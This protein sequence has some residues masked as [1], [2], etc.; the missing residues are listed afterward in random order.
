MKKQILCAALSVAM[1]ATSV[2]VPLSA[3]AA[4]KT[5]QYQ[6][7][8]RQMEDLDRGLIAVYRTADG[9]N[10]MGNEA[11][12]YLSWRLLGTESLENQAF[13]IYRG[14]EL[15]ATTGVHDATN[16]IDKAGRA[17]DEYRVLPAGTPAKQV[18]KEPAVKPVTNHV[19]NGGSNL[20][21]SFTYEDIRIERPADSNGGH[22]YT[23]GSQEGGANDASV[24]D[25]DGDGQYEIV[26]KWDPTN[27]KDAS[28]GGT[29]GHTI[30][31]AYEID[32]TN[33]DPTKNSNGHLYKWRID[34]GS[35]VRA[36]AHENPF[37]VYD[38]DGDG[39]AEMVSITGKDSVDGTGQYVT[40]VGDTEEI[41]N[42]SN[43]YDASLLRKG[44]NIGP[45]YYTVFDGETGAALITTDAIPIGREDGG[46]WGDSKMQRSSRYLAGVAYIDGVHP[47]FVMGRG[48]YNRS[49]IRAYTWDGN[50]ATMLWEHDGNVDNATTM[51]GQGA[52]SLSIGDIDNDGKDEVVYISASLDDDGRTVLG[53]TRLGHGDA[54]HLSD[55]NND[56]MQEIFSV[57]EKEWGYKYYGYDFVVAATGQHFWESGK[58]KTSG[59]NGRGVMAN[60]DDEYAKTHPNALAIGWDSGHTMSHD[61]NGDDIAAKPAAAGKG[62]FDNFLVYWDGDLSRELLDANI[63]QKYDAAT[64]ISTRFYGENDGYTLTG[65]VTNNYTKRNPCLVADLWGDWREEII[66]ATGK[67]QNETPALRIFTSTIPT[68]YRLTTLMHDSQYRLAIAWQNVGYNQPPHQ[69]YYIGSVALATDEDGNTLNYLAPAVP[70]TNVTTEAPQAVAATGITLD[71]SSAKVEK[72]K[73]ITIGGKVLPENAS[74]KAITWVSSNTSVATVSNGIVKGV[75]AGT[76]TITATTKDG[77]FSATC[78]VEVYSKPVTGV[79]LSERYIEIG[80]DGTKQLTATVY[81]SDATDKSVTW[82]S[83][84]SGIATVASDGTVTGKS[85][86]KT[87]V[88]ATTNDGKKVASCIVKV[89]NM[90]LTDATGTGAFAFVGTPGTNTT[91][92][93]NTATGVKLNMADA[94]TGAVAQKSFTQTSGNKATLKFNFVTG[95]TK[96]DGSNWN[97]S[98]HEYSMGLKF[99]DENGNNIMNIVQPYADKAGTLTCVTGEDEK[100]NVENWTK[101][102]DGIGNIQG[103]AK[104]WVF[105]AEFDYDKDTCTVDIMGTDDNYTA[106]N[107]EYTHTFDLNGA[108]LSSMQLYTTKDGTGTIKATPTIAKLNYSAMKT[109][110]GNTT[111]IYNKGSEN[112]RWQ[113]SDISDWTLTGADTATPTIV[114]DVLLYNPEKP[115]AAYEAS[116]TFEGIDEN[117]IV[118]YDIDW[119]Y[120]LAVNRDGNYEYLQIGD[121]IR[122]GWTN[123]Y[124]LCLS[125]DAGATY[126]S[127]STGANQE[128]TNNVKVVFGKIT[129]T[130][131]LYFAGEKI[132]DYTLTS[133]NADSVKFGFTRA[134][135]PPTWEVPNGID[136]IRVSQFVMGAELP[137][138]NSVKKTEVQFSDLNTLDLKYGFV[139]DVTSATIIGVL[140]E[141]NEIKEIQTKDVTDFTKDKWH[142]TELTFNSNMEGKTVKIYMW[143][144]INGMNPIGDY[145]E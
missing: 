29:T 128:Y 53:N 6:T 35:Y 21:E 71:T 90:T 63:I 66:M 68:D 139:T 15:I 108:K 123:G 118:T 106:N 145:L 43:D 48:M 5:P 2:V 82:A 115:G 92:D 62:S 19:G 104:K 27:S 96:L 8:Q 135:A 127:I 65:A 119:K 88:T 102:V 132:G 143:D 60:I 142:T 121:N 107:G 87:T 138:I 97:W 58:S 41:R 3:G 67:G 51:Y 20:K 11:G 61:F 111:E 131:T 91:L 80:V 116:K 46:D 76:A 4:A 95:G 109:V 44:K 1:L 7:A 89:K 122:L 98:G 137:D 100:T 52:H 126:T 31:D 70:F 55:F 72:G 18:I 101:I 73:S 133:E 78:E 99:L 23:D 136:R 42:T 113:E 22:Y 75:D 49:V 140:Y 45:E 30:Y 32:P 39:K 103:S 110:D 124:S 141:G 40:K 112:T 57:K 144:S 10:V 105:T 64:G 93:D 81:P 47:A 130:A 24:G 85:Y 54:M 34:L 83:E 12:V 79:V 16:Y 33:T 17:T 129:N 37:L 50:E 25:L 36:G 77:G 94:S 125:T 9:K 134:G 117:A 14:Y 74:K 56:G 26:L 13:D 120:G 28:S 86:G 38:F 114:N 84:D 69:S 59:D